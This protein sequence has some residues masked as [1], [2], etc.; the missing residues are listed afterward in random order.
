MNSIKHKIKV[1][2][3]QAVKTCEEL[4]SCKSS[5]DC[6][7]LADMNTVMPNYLQGYG[8]NNSSLLFTKERTNKIYWGEKKDKHKRDL[9]C[10]IT[11]RKGENMK[12]TKGQVGN[13]LQNISFIADEKEMTDLLP[14][15]PDPPASRELW[16]RFGL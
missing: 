4:C 12:I 2:I 5:V 11:K 9:N 8:S 1:L 15:H 14:R 13:C 7:E 3:L 6:I 16:C 10:K